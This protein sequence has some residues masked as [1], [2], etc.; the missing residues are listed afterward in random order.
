MKASIGLVLYSYTSRLNYI[1]LH[2]CDY[3]YLNQFTG[4]MLQKKTLLEKKKITSIVIIATF[5][6]ICLL[7]HRAED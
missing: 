5:I 6:Y 1:P 7:S 4:R 3:L 2:P